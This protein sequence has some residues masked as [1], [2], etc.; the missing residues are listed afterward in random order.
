MSTNNLKELNEKITSLASALDA[1]IE[2]YF[3]FDNS[4]ETP[5]T[6]SIHEKLNLAWDSLDS[7]LDDLECL[8][9]GITSLE[10]K[11]DPAEPVLSE[12][13]FRAML[14]NLTPETAEKNLKAAKE[15]FDKAKEIQSINADL[16]PAYA[17]MLLI[18][19][20]KQAG[21]KKPNDYK[22]ALADPEAIIKISMLD[23][24]IID[25]D[26]NEYESAHITLGLVRDYFTGNDLHWFI[27]VAD[28][29]RKA[30]K[31][32]LKGQSIKD[33]YD[34]KKPFPFD[35]MD[36]KQQ[37]AIL[38]TMLLLH[39]ISFAAIIKADDKAIETACSNAI[40]V[41]GRIRH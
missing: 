15:I 32:L 37:D 5:E 31:E 35:E 20:G 12:E 2:D 36:P 24:N 8:I 28:D 33:K 21:K 7:A 13:T 9:K 6:A 26:D 27:D 18:E 19:Y 3:K 34:K 40:D 1:A 38:N 23:D 39:G 14:R 11:T 10:R 41:M 17:A 25:Y 29:L 22:A 4:G 16:I 30:Y